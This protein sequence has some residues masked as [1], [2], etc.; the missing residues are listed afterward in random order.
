MTLE[1]FN[2]IIRWTSLLLYGLLQT[3]KI[4]IFASFIGLIIGVF[5]GVFTCNKIEIPVISRLFNIYTLCIRCIPF[6]TQLLMM[7]FAIPYALNIS[8][9]PQEASI[10]ALGF[11]SAGYI[12]EIIRGGIN[13]LAKGQWLAAKALGYSPYSTLRHIILPQTINNVMPALGNE[14]I[15]I[16]HST[17]ILSSIGTIELTKIAN[18]IIA[19]EMNPLVI[20][21][22][23]ALLYLITTGIIML[24]LRR[25]ERRNYNA[26]R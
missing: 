21:P 26:N 20:Y 2:T 15:Q 22:L 6:Y 19:R 1:F 14:F 13:S 5:I 12:A 16:I 11:C 18:N 9:K 7:Y 17:S 8:L 23:T 4:S 3:F 24:I 25:L 10:I